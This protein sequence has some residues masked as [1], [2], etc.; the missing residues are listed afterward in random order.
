[1]SLEFRYICP[2]LVVFDMPASLA[3][4]R[5]VLGFKIVE[6]AP[7]PDQARG[8]E[9]G[10][11][12]LQ[13][14]EANLMLNTLYDPDAVRPPTPDPTR[15]AAHDDTALFIGCPDVQ[16]TYEHLRA[17]GLTVE[18]PSVAPYGMRQL[19]VKDPDGFTVCF[20]WPAETT[21]AVPSVPSSPAA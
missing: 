7:P 20:Q 17:C 5:D 1:M 6:A 14:D 4:Y 15:V 10:W 11:V 18:P 12:W 13:R 16:G 2:M 3:F 19:Y 9:F 8:D 21:A